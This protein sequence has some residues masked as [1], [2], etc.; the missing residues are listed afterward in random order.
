MGW[1]ASDCVVCFTN[2][3][4]YCY[5]YMRNIS[6]RRYTLFLSRVFGGKQTFHRES[7]V[8]TGPDVIDELVI[9]GDG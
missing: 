8:P 6:I 2:D 5:E 9:T 3:G 1:S 4:S 7:G